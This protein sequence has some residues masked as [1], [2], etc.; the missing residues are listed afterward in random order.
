ME[1]LFLV[2]AFALIFK[3]YYAFINRP[4]RNSEGL[5]TSAIYGFTKFIN[6]I[7]TRER[8]HHLGVAF[9]PHGGN[10][11]HQL[12]PAYKANRS[13]TPEDIINSTPH[14]KRILEAMRIPVLEVKG[15][16][17][18][19]VIGTIAKKA[20]CND[21]EVYMVTPDKDYGQLL[22][23]C[24]YMYKP[25]K[26]GSGVEIVGQK[27]ILKEYGFTSVS[28]IIDLLA[29]WGDASDNV[30]GVPGVGEKTA[31]KLLHEYGS[32]EN[33][34]ANKESLKGKMRENFINFE[35]QLIL[36]K[37]LVTIDTNVPIDY[38]PQKLVMEEPLYD[39]LRKIYIELGFSSLLKDLDLWQRESQI[40]ASG[41]Q[42]IGSA[43]NEPEMASLFDEPQFMPANPKPPKVSST[44]RA[45]KIEVAEPLPAA[46]PASLFSSTTLDNISTTPHTYNILRDMDGIKQLSAMLALTSE[47]S[48]DT[49]TTSLNPLSASLVGISIAIEPHKA[50][51]IPLDASSKEA[52]TALLEPL[53]A[54]FANKKISKIGQ[55]CKYDILML[56]RY[57]I[58]I[59][60]PLLDTMIMHY[61]LE[62]DQRHGMDFLSETYLKYSPI[63]IEELIGKGSKA[64]TMNQ[65]DIERA[66]EYAAE[67]ADVTLRLKN[68]LWPMIESENQQSLYFNIEEPLIRVL[69]S[70][71]SAGVAIDI[72]ALKEF[73]GELNIS[74][75]KLEEEIKE[76]AE[77][78]SI[79]INSSVQLGELLFDK[80]KI[81]LKPKLTKTKRYR[82]DEEYLESLSDKHFVVGLI[83]EYRGLRKLQSTYVEALPKL[84]SPTTGRLHTT[85]NQAVASTGRL[86]SN[87]PNLQNIPIRE[88]NGKRIRRA[89]IAS[90]PNTQLLSADYSQIELRIMA[91]LSGDEA[92]ISA[93]KRGEDIH[94]ATAAKIYGKAIEDVTSEERRRAKTANFGIIYGISVFGLSS[95]LNISRP[96]AKL[97][98]DGYFS[99]YPKVKEYMDSCIT[100]AREKGYV[101]TMFGRRK[102][103]LDI[104]SS[105]SM[106]RSYAERN[107]INSPIQGSAADIIKIAMN[108]LYAKLTDGNYKSRLILQVHDELIL[109]VERSE[110][111]AV[112]RLVV[113]AM[114]SAA[115]LSVP[116]V[117]DWAMADN[118]LDAH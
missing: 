29:L 95:R 10:F 11:R 1:K 40:A 51:Y 34:L 16:E 33:I 36:S 69:A 2:D 102:G 89:F 35:E 46:E 71:E 113:E 66:G 5:N 105:N 53:K 114:E 63:P 84:I 106:V 75:N 85:Y 111:E 43:K 12:Y 25:G 76:V 82:T 103:L 90:S 4:M 44:L 108:N 74:L 93:F 107:A 6:D 17:A 80:L 86:S 58:D 65:V 68:I 97:L 64:L 31:I 54:V 118:W 38:E 104:N 78:P 7:V 87:N 28:Q 110:A 32:V 116:L 55:N 57:G 30:P 109:E 9:D 24:C 60:G 115:T 91:H 101:E 48:F 56:Q 14:I 81:E 42:Y 62:S 18:D 92:L 27:E 117:A 88:A 21:F 37:R 52:T 59:K 77:Q 98:I 15:F 41:A 67:D 26:S 112:S 45:P 70:M 79:N 3:F 73:E 19:D 61:L 72:E 20:A 39:D 47:F 100:V 96:D 99:S 49:E 22:E 23:Q 94:A 83:L 13:A 50:Y 8:P